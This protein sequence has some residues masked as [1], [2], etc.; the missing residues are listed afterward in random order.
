VHP[1][2]NSLTDNET[3]LHPKLVA[4]RKKEEDEE[5]HIKY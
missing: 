3:I 5:R 1:I 4:E 2:P